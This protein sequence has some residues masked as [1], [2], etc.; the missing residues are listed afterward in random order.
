MIKL[1]NPIC[2]DNAL[3][4]MRRVRKI[5]RPTAHGSVPQR[6]RTVVH[7]DKN[8][9]EPVSMPHLG[10]LIISLWVAIACDTDCS[11]I[12]YGLVKSI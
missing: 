7:F 5:F 11:D 3:E 2:W 6:T 1:V 12:E 9:P 4:Q 10:P 8:P